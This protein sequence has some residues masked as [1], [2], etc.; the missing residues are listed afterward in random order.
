MQWEVRMATKS[1]G[2]V[3]IRVLP[4]STRFKEDLKRSLER[5]EKS[6][7]VKIPV[8]LELARAELLK[9]KRQIESL[10]ITIRPKIDL[11]V[12]AADI[13]ALKAEIE[14]MRPVVNVRLNTQQAATRI[15]ALT[16]TRRMSI[17]PVLNNKATALFLA[18]MRA[19]SGLNVIGDS[20]REAK[21]F[22]LNIDRNAVKF[23][24]LL[25]KIGVMSSLIGSTVAQ[26][27]T[28]G[29]GL[30]SM[31]NIGILAPAFITGMGIGVGVLVAALK[32]MK[33]VLADL[34]PKFSAWQKS[35][36]ADFWKEAADPVRKLVNYLLPLLNTTDGTTNTARSL[37]KYV[38]EM[39]NSMRELLTADKLNLML[40]RM[41]RSIDIL[42]GSIRPLTNSFINLGIVGSGYFERFATWIVKLSN[43]F[44]AFITKSAENGDLDRW[45][46]N[47]IQNWKNF[48]NTVRAVTR[49]LGAINTAAVKAGTANFKQ[50][51]ESLNKAADVMNTPRFQNTLVLL[52]EGMNAAVKGVANGIRQLGPAI[53]TAAPTIKRV[54]GTVG[55][56]ASKVG[57][58]LAQIISNPVFLA[59]LETFITSI[60][61]SLDQLAPA[62]QPFADSLGGV[63]DLMGKVLIA[64]SDL[65]AKI[66]T[67]WGPIFD[68][69]G[70][71]LAELIDPL[72]ASLKKFVDEMTPVLESFRVNVLD[73]LVDVIKADLL[74]LVDKIVTWAAPE[75]DRA[76]Q[77]VGRLL[78]EVVKP[79]LQWIS[80]ELDKIIGK[81]GE[82]QSVFDLP[83]LADPKNS[84]FVGGWLTTPGNWEIDRDKI[85][86]ALQPLNDSVNQALEDF[87]GDVGRNNEGMMKDWGK[88]T[89]GM[90]LDLAAGWE[91]MWKDFFNGIGEGIKKAW[92]NWWAGL[93]GMWKDIKSA[94]QKKFKEIFGFGS[95][96]DGIKPGVI[97]GSVKG[98]KGFGVSGKID[99][100]DDF[101]LPS[102]EDV[103]AWC[104]ELGKTLGE[105]AANIIQGFLD[106]FAN[107]SLVKAV[108]EYFTSW[109]QDVKD[110]FGIHS[111]ST[112]MFEMAG[113]IVQGFIDGFA[114]LGTKIGEVWDGIVLWIQTKAGEIK[115]NLDT[116]IEEVKINWANFWDGLG[117]KVNEAWQGFLD[118]VNLKA[119]EIKLNIDTWIGEVKTNWDNF[120]NG[121]GAKVSEAWQSFVDWINQ[122][123][124]EIRGNIDQ[125]IADVK[126]N[127]DNFWRDVGEKVR[128]AWEDIVRK[129]ETGV[130][131]A[132]EWV[133][134]LPGKAVDALGNLGEYLK[135]SGANL[136]QGF[137]DGMGGMIED[138]KRTA[139]N[140]LQA[141]RD[142]FPSSPAKVGP[143]SGM[144]YTPHS[145][146][147]LVK[148]FANGMM[149]N[150]SKVREATRAVAEAAHL[151][152]N[153]DLETNLDQDG[154]VIDRRQVTVNNYNPVAEPASRTIEKSAN[155][156]RMAK[157]I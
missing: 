136:I 39:A 127:W 157:A 41:N 63:L 13:A 119:A 112:L 48:G 54:L 22:F 73:K 130:N 146:R 110:F 97:T 104:L 77:E 62:I 85:N 84:G 106:G 76:F 156:L 10:V 65:G 52:F 46:E 64:V 105:G 79:V 111:P 68:K 47:A 30:A 67:D 100:A 59:G 66:L 81:K 150:M 94:F 149:S 38:A 140:I 21:D 69:M 139:G 120:W 9:L 45:I 15:A 121:L 16:R 34:G 135:N 37:G 107:S 116:W 142:F 95:S 56:I 29:A 137:I 20:F 154:V 145:G 24:A 138:A 131:D 114:E 87:W 148:D 129:F 75:L 128:T 102:K 35:I 118:W 31:A 43:Q 123:A 57:G 115:T 83:K 91:G 53:E 126:T 89:E 101:G 12:S 86:A 25:S 4:D 51:A 144:G 50:F 134:G 55:D 6:M 72:N 143:F 14:R 109:V 26:M 44:D 78:D 133:R 70:F 74:P 71:K 19:L 1:A 153:L 147:A 117:T 40:D 28:L 80:G 132:I 5:I 23:A 152:S 36:S 113:N 141:V 18:K 33:T 2:R 7:K 27:V 122:K 92:D 3:S 88:N 17:E 8:E 90:F 108:K 32:D 98:A 103:M 125:F 42:R 96:G 11:N 124:G 155:T 49:M 151:G 99:L 61:T 60:S 58:V 93:D 82:F